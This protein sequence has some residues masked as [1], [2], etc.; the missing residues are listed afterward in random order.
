MDRGTGSHNLQVIIGYGSNIDSEE[1]G[2][3]I[4]LTAKH[5]GKVDIVH[6]GLDKQVD[7]YLTMS[8]EDNM[9]IRDKFVEYLK[10]D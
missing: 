7:V 10:P 8:A 1:K 3:F 6:P 4:D 5:R 9:M 2:T